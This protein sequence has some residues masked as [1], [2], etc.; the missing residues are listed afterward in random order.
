MQFARLSIYTYVSVWGW[1]ACYRSVMALRRSRCLGLFLRG[2]PCGSADSLPGGCL[3][4]KPQRFRTLACFLEPGTVQRGVLWSAF[5]EHAQDDPVCVAELLP[6]LP[7]RDPFDHPVRESFTVAGAANP[8]RVIAR[9]E[10]WSRLM[11]GSQDAVVP[12]LCSRCVRESP[13]PGPQ[14]P[15]PVC[16]TGRHGCQDR[17]Q[18][19]RN[20]FLGL[21][22]GIRVSGSCR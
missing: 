20:P 4:V 21:D 6:H 16:L 5:G 22:Y 9:V 8:V 2:V 1:S 13:L 3:P 7:C 11:V 12:P 10:P 17:H 18:G 14:Q 19:G 15:G